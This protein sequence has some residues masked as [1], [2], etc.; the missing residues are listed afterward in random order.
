MRSVALCA[1]AVRQLRRQAA[2][3]AATL[4]LIRFG[5]FMKNLYL[6]S[7]MALLCAASLAACG[8]SGN[9]QLGGT[10][11]GLTKT[12]LALTNNNGAPFAIAPRTGISAFSFAFPDLVG[13]D[14]NYNVEISAQPSGAVCTISNGKGRATGNVSSVRVACVTNAY[15]LSGTVTGLEPGSGLVNGNDST[16]VQDDLSFVFP[17]KVADGATYGI[18]AQ[19]CTVTGGVGT[20]G[21]ED[22]EAN[23]S[24][25]CP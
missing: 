23:I 5:E 17:T 8:G 22:V 15:T 14:S 1:C 25:T 13:T 16:T 11:T 21:T 12:G 18:V 10:V 24:V 2:A 6:R 4:Y 9:L 19:G 20:M 7:C 3:S